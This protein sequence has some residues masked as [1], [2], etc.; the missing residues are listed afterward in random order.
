MTPRLPGLLAFAAVAVILT[1]APAQP[2][3]ADANPSADLRGRQEQNA[4]LFA[5]FKTALLR[6]AQKLQRSDKPEDQERAKVI[7]AAIDLA[8]KENVDDQFRRLVGGMAKTGGNVQSVNDL[9]KDDAQLTKV[10]QDIL[11]ILMTDDETARVKA[12]IAK[13]EAFLKEAKDIKRRQ[14][15][16][17]ALT[18]AQKQSVEKLSKNQKDLAQQTKDLAER[19]GPKDA[20]PKDSAK[21]EPKDGKTDPKDGKPKDGKPSDPKDGQ[22][23]P[24]DPKDGEPK[25]GPPK[26]PAGPQPP[27][28]PGRKQIQEA[29]PKQENAADKL[30]EDKK[31]EAGKPQ[32]EAIAKLAKAIEELEKRLKQLREEEMLKLLANLEARVKRMLA[33]QIEVFEATKSIDSTVTKNNGVKDTPEVQKAQQQGDK[34]GEIVAEADRALKLLESEGT[35]VAFARVLEEVRVDM[36][37]VQRRL[38][39][40]EVGK[41]TQAIEENI[42]AMLKD[43]AEALKKA[44]QEVQQKQQQ[45]PPPGGKPGPQQLINLLQELKLIRSMQVQVNTRTKM[46]GDKEKAEQ[47]NDPIVRDEIR[48]LS[49]RQAKLQEMVN[50]I[51]TGANQ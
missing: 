26:P 19:M 43:M 14:E 12:E 39:V 21:S 45:P 11:T 23:K 3:A 7:F 17:R 42:I 34:E 20:K 16:L 32:D 30:K 18:E 37:A 9:L 41:D 44:Q 5:E 47:A 33:M 36:A 40:A 28:L 10:L 1:V 24:G 4:K 35:A 49:A 38:G 46:Y 2:P 48:Q 51:A 29:Y 25:D 27:Q 50:K 13:L 8:A 6:L 22:P 15:I 31:P